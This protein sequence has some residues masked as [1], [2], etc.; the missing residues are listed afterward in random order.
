[1]YFS[2]ARKPMLRRK[3][4]NVKVTFL[5]SVDDTLSTTRSGGLIS[6]EGCPGS[7]VLSDVEVCMDESSGGMTS[8]YGREQWVIIIHDCISWWYLTNYG[9]EEIL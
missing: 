7:V 3:S 5:G 4:S 9:I 6:P 8:S 1:M 2:A